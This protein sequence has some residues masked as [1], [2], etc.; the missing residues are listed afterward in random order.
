MYDK[1]GNFNY[2]SIGANPRVQTLYNNIN[3]E[4]L[5]K[6]IGSCYNL[7]SMENINATPISRNPSEQII[8]IVDNDEKI[9]SK[10]FD[11]SLSVIGYKVDY[12]QKIEEDLKQTKEY[13]EKIFDSVMQQEDLK[14]DK[15]KEESKELEEKQVNNDILLLEKRVSKIEELLQN[16]ESSIKEEKVDNEVAKNESK[17]NSEKLERVSK[18]DRK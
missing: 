18:L 15:E 16:N 17:G 8:L 1:I 2:Q 10:S 7:N 3:Y 6:Y 4:K 12:V 11:N 14:V 13:L 5:N 9:Y